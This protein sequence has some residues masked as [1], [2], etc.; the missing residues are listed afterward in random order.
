MIQEFGC[1][2]SKPDPRAGKRES[3][4]GASRFAVGEFGTS[5]LARTGVTNSG[6]TLY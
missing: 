6:A 3:L 4:A 2:F 1:C 5:V